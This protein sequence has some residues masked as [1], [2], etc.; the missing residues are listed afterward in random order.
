MTKAISAPHHKQHHKEFLFLENVNACRGS[1][2]ENLGL[3]AS[4]VAS[5]TLRRPL[6]MNFDV[7]S[8]DDK[9]STTV[10]STLKRQWRL[11][12]PFQI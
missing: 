9:A 7:D 1:P 10:V 11:S 5:N 12:S 4:A 2:A 8:M 3:Y 6:N